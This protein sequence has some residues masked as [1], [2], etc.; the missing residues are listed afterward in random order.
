MLGGG[1]G[2]G[3]GASSIGDGGGGNSG[4]ISVLGRGVCR[5]IRRFRFGGG[6]IVLAT[7]AAIGGDVVLATVAAA[8][9]EA[10]GGN[11]V[12]GSAHVW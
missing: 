5:V 7:M 1:D 9:I 8:V 2:D 12:R 3:D 6:I 4:I 10:G 11:A